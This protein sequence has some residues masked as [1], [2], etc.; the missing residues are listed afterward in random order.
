MVNRQLIKWIIALFMLYFL[1]RWMR[2][3]FPELPDLIKF[4]LTDLLFVPLMGNV[5]WLGTRFMKGNPKL[6]LPWFYGFVLSGFASLYF[7]WY[8][9]SYRTDL[10]PYTSDILDVLMYFIGGLMFS[11]CS[12]PVFWES[13]QARTKH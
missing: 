4:Q 12:S 13:I 7:E 9:P 10:H 6:Q 3:S 5:A 2:T 8:L 1:L 11:I